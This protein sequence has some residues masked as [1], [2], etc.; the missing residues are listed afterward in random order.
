[1]T[2]MATSTARCSKS[3][4]PA[5][6]ALSKVPQIPGIA[7]YSMKGLK[8]ESVERLGD[9]KDYKVEP[10]RLY[11][12]Y[13]PARFPKQDI[14]MLLGALPYPPQKLDPPS[15]IDSLKKYNKEFNREMGST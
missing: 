14:V 12:L 9:I 5:E 15:L 2:L 11:R 1:M 7:T 4:L 8:N 10:K 13:L 6:L 3:K